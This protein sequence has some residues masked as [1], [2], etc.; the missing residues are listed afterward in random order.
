M[1]NRRDL[2]GNVKKGPVGLRKENSLEL[3]TASMAMRKCVRTGVKM[4]RFE[5]LN[6]MAKSFLC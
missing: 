5:I 3:K 6:G 4:K 1:P 2:V